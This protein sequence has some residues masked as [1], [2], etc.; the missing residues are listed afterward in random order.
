[1]NK[2]L[3]ETDKLVTALFSLAHKLSPSVVFIDEID[4]LLGDRQTA[5]QSSKAYENMQAIFIF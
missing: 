2:W 3:G 5:G 4:T 1:M